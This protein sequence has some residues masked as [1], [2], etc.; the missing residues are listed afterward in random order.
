M[1]GAQT[2]LKF[3]TLPSLPYDFAS[4]A[5]SYSISYL[6]RLMVEVNAPQ[7]VTFMQKEITTAIA[8]AQPFLNYEG[9]GGLISN[10][11]DLNGTEGV[12]YAAGY[13]R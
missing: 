11:I 13:D 8:A 10:F 2:L 6:F 4:S 12:E 7:V 1:D 5:T 9:E 3:Y